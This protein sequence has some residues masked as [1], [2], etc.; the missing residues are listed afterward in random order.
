MYVIFYIT[1]LNFKNFN[2]LYFFLK[3]TKIVLMT[4][5]QHNNSKIELYNNIYIHLLSNNNNFQFKLNKINFKNNFFVD[6]KK[7]KFNNILFNFFNNYFI[8]FLT[9]FLSKKIFFCIKKLNFLVNN[10][11]KN[12]IIDFMSKKLKKYYNFAGSSTLFKQLIEVLWLS[13][14]LKDSKFFLN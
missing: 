12:K 14:L 3:I 4:H 11:K 6:H 10:F 2:Y 8:N 5:T 9:F 1:I 13:F 7:K